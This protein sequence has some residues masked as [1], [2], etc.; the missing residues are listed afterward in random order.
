MTADALND[1]NKRHLAQLAKDKGISGWHAMRKDQLIRALVKCAFVCW[2]HQEKEET[3]SRP[4][5]HAGKNRR[6]LPPIDQTEPVR[7]R[8]RLRHS[9][10]PVKK[11]ELSSSRAIHTGCMHTGN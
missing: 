3:A 11:T 1:C 10:T 9:T 6:R 7:L 4:R 5:S 8:H 2:S